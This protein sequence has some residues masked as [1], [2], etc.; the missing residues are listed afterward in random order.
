MFEVFTPESAMTYL[1]ATADRLNC[2]GTARAVLDNPKFETWSAASHSHQHHYGKHGLI[3]H[4]AEVCMLCLSNNKLLNVGIDER[5]LFLAALFHDIGKVWDYEP[6]TPLR[7][8]SQTEDGA[9]ALPTPNYDEWQ[10]TD[11]KRKIYH[12][13][14]SSLVWNEAS[15]GWN[16]DMRD[17][18]THAI[19][20]HHGLRE[21]GS[22]VLPA[23]KMAWLLHLSDA[24]SARMQ[25]GEK[26][27]HVK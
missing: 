14:R 22:P 25:D 9:V 21:W 12:I 19:L 15:T 11:H 27:D 2:R 10:G 16:Q 4:T 3:V 1:C 17:R 23:T 8:V 18:I 26:W 20:A 5:E 13:S 24:T 6:Q 7:V